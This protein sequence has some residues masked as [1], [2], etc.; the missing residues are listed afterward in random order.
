MTDPGLRVSA[1]A[2]RHPRSRLGTM[3]P[4]CSPSWWPRTTSSCARES[5][6]CFGAVGWRSG[7][8]SAST[9]RSSRPCGSTTLTSSSPT[10]G[11]HRIRPTRACGDRVAGDQP[12]VWGGGAQPA[13]KREYAIALLNGGSEGRAYLLKD[14][15]S[16]PDQLSA[17][18]RAVAEGRSVID[19][20]VVEEFVATRTGAIAGGGD[21]VGHVRQP[22][23]RPR[24][25]DGSKPTP[26]SWTSSSTIDDV[27]RTRRPTARTGPACLTMF[28]NASTQQK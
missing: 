20:K 27:T 21:A 17:A 5:S 25:G 15:I 23:T 8:R 3:G 1:I 14:R 6:S 19:P 28:C 4:W 22:A 18:V 10:S 16:E 7:R 26:S 2:T 13:R 9:M 12:A 24:C 11:C